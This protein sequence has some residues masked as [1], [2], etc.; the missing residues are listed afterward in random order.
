[1]Q[2]PEIILYT[3]NNSNSDVQQK[4]E[5]YSRYIFRGSDLLNSSDHTR[6]KDIGGQI[7]GQ[8]PNQILRQI[9]D[10]IPCKIQSMLALYEFG[11]GS[12]RQKCRNFVRQG[13]YMEDYEDNVPWY[14]NLMVC[15]PVYHDLNIRQLRGYFTWRTQIRKGCFTKTCTAFAYLYIY[16]LL[17]GI[18]AESP[19]DSINKLLAFR[20]GYIETAMGDITIKNNVRRWLFDY[21]VTHLFP[22]RTVTRFVEK[23]ILERDH[24]LAVLRSPGD[25]GDEEVFQA[26]R[27]FASQN[28]ALSTVIS[29][30]HRRGA[31]LFAGIWRHIASKPAR[32]DGRDVFT[33]CFGEKEVRTWHPLANA[34]YVDQLTSENVEFQ[35][36]ECRRYFCRDGEWHVES[37]SSLSGD[38]TSFMSLMHAADRRLRSMLKTGHY[39]REK[40]GDEW[41]MPYIDAAL[42]KIKA[43]EEEA[44]RPKVSIDLSGLDRIRE[45]ADITRDSLLTEDELK[46][47][48]SSAASAAD[49]CVHVESAGE[50]EEAV[51][52]HEE[53]VCEQ[54]DAVCGQDAAAEL[55]KFDAHG[56]DALQMAVLG[57]L[58]AGND[59]KDLIEKNRLMPEVLADSI[60]EV[61]FD[62]IGDSVIECTNGRLEVIE[63]YMDDLIV[64][65][66]GI[67]Q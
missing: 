27:H 51:C 21:A 57:D 1:M 54:K 35:L 59:A 39:L 12:F 2:S 25:Y 42:A 32:L 10:Q 44:A 40:S 34:V 31:R 20:D 23:G 60:N 66:G 8:I 61:L 6:D 48:D 55:E 18:G 28:M 30:D 7:P 22:G 9:P 53:A 38:R 43:E 37:Y 16:E 65:T 15:F 4:W 52:E 13:K 24:A 26:I 50:H 3:G 49:A 11:D 29:K 46:Q 45:D 17:N 5:Q 14:G 33:V 36:D 62:E 63:D 67:R 56:L 19:E 41:A 58:L 47:D 64:L